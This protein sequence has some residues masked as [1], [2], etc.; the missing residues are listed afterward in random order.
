MTLEDLRVLVAVC[1][2]GSVSAAA[3]VLRKSQPGVSQHLSRLERELGTPLVE[4]RAR[5]VVPTA[6]GAALYEAAELGLSELSAA[7]A[8]IEALR[9]GAA[10]SFALV[11][12]GTTLKHFMQ[13]ALRRFRAE[14]PHVPVRFHQGHSTSQCIDALRTQHIDLGFV[15]MQS[16]LARVEQRPL[17]RMRH[18]LLVP[19]QHRLA[20]KPKLVLAELDGVELISLATGSVTFELLRQ[21]LSSRGVVPN[22]TMTVEDWDLA[23][24]LV[25]LG[26]GCAIVPAFH[27]HEFVKQ[28][29][30]AAVPIAGLPPV[31]F[32]WVARRFSSLSAPALV[33]MRLLEAELAAQ[34]RPGVRLLLKPEARG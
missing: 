17:L 22:T 6:A 15:T 33:F 25:S 11:T 34:K 20:R 21:D 3:Q 24:V 26:L 16:R 32:G 27:A 19:A 31:E 28:G 9:S 10:G 29:A 5:G 2:A 12:G 13:G 7:R 4:R 23:Y 14:L 8:R 30:V 1:R 18:A